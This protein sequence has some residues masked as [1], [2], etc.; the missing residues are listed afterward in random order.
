M[1]VLFFYPA[2]YLEIGI[3]QSI[4]ILSA[5]L[6]KDGHEVELFDTTFL[7]PEAY[8]PE[9][10][11][12]MAGPAIYKKTPYTLEDL[13]KDDPVVNIEK[14][15]QKKI[16]NFK[17]D[18]IA[19][20][21]M[22]TNYDF[23][24]RVIKKIKAKCPIIFG[25]VHTTLCPEEVL[26]EQTIDMICIGEGEEALPELCKAIESG[27][28]YR[29]IKN[30]WVKSNGKVYKNSIRPFVDLDTLP[31]PDWSIFDSRHLYRPFRGEVYKGSFYISSRGCPCGCTYCVNRTL[32]ELFKDCG[33]Y[34]RCHKPET[35]VAHLTELKKKFGATWFKFGDD[36][37]L[38]QPLKNLKEL[39]TKLKD[40]KIL[41]GCSVRP[42][43][44]TE[45]KVKLMKEM[46]CVAMSIGIE[47]GNEEIRYKVLNRH[48]PND[49]ME[50]S[51]K[52]INEYDIRISTFNL[53]G[54]PGETREN[55]FETIELNRKLKVQS[56]NV[57]I[58]Y[59]FHGSQISIQNNTNYKRKN[60]KIIPMS[61]A[62]VFHLSVMTPR[63]VEG[64]KKTFNL[65][66]SLPKQL[67]P[68]IELAEGSGN[69]NKKI[70]QA[71]TE[72]TST[73]V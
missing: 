26:S 59:P 5:I 17:P 4:S 36:T 60:G 38:L 13:V 52:I 35:T 31:C 15:F 12:K 14:E 50:K 3:P 41:F 24:L 55:V 73:I 33:R 62:S 47:T 68:I 71:L 8:N 1:K 67:W 25:G 22:T 27:N 54:L 6:K 39:S 23:A 30:L 43:T 56:A 2:N 20:S 46:G 63:E 51:F 34:F 44:I 18:L 28:D 49:Q 11:N 7:K 64:L 57:Y 58:L 72:F 45:E 37:F 19:V 61:K 70:Y 32:R 16:E 29:N 21:T 10:D 53:I 69:R 65:Y 48:I 40:L 42:D 66:L 9:H